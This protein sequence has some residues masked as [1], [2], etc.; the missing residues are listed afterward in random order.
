MK[1][2]LLYIALFLIPFGCVDRPTPMDEVDMVEKEAVV[3]QI[4]QHV[5][6]QTE[7]LVASLLDGTAS[8]GPNG[9]FQPEPAPTHVP[10]SSLRGTIS[11][12]K[13]SF[14][15]KTGIHDVEFS[16]SV[17]LQNFSNQIQANLKYLFRDKSGKFLVFPRRNR[18]SVETIRYYGIKTGEINT[19]IS[20]NGYMRTDSLLFNGVE[21]EKN[22]VKVVGKERVKGFFEANIDNESISRNFVAEYDLNAIQ[23]KRVA[24]EQRDFTK[25]LSGSIDFRFHSKM[26]NGIDTVTVSFIGKIEIMGDGTALIRTRN[27]PEPALVDLKTG[28]IITRGGQNGR[29]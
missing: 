27:L 11:N 21:K 20:R 6:L 23:I 17:T 18:D 13:I 7:G 2:H 8:I 29:P 9:I 12:L 25:A 19:S 28:L 3:N 22:A 16:R 14:D 10:D 15:P 26:A 4:G 5:G 24:V 1:N